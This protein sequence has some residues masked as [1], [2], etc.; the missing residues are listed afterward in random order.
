MELHC[1]YTDNWKCAK[2]KRLIISPDINEIL[3]LIREKYTNICDSMDDTEKDKIFKDIE[4]EIR[5]K[6]ECNWQNCLI[7]ADFS[8]TR[9]ERVLAK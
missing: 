2:W 3:G 4:E 6:N 1:L 5:L 9:V 8:K 7:Y